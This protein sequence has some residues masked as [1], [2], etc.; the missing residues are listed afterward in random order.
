MH[1]CSFR[2]YF[3]YFTATCGAPP[4]VKGIIPAPTKESYK[5]GD[6]VKYKC[7]T[8]TDWRESVCT[9]EGQWTQLNFV[10]GGKVKYDLA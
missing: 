10:C 3:F 9:S 2:T 1:M 4:I 8:G 6:V 7:P 5:V